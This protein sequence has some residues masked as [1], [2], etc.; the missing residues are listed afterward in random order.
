MAF[1]FIM[2]VRARMQAHNIKT[3]F[4][5][6]A[7]ITLI[8]AGAVLGQVKTKKDLHIGELWHQDQ[9]VPSGGWEESYCWPGNHWREKLVGEVRMMNGTGRMSGLCYGM[10]NWKEYT[11]ITYPY[12]VGTVSNSLMVHAGGAK[13]AAQPLKFKLVLRRKPPITT[14]DGVSQAP[15]QAYDEIDPN[16]VSDAMMLIRFSWE[17]GI[18]V[19]QKFYAYAC[20]NAD[21]YFLVDFTA[22][23]NGNALG[24]E[25]RLEYRNQV[26]HDVCFS[27]TTQPCVSFEGAT[28]N[29]AIWEANNDDWVEY[30][31]ENYLDYLGTGTPLRPAGNR[32]ADSLRVFMVWD[33]DNNKLANVD[34]TGDPDQNGGFN[35]QTPGQGRFLS[36]QY[37]GMGFLHVDKSPTDQ[38]NDLS[39]PFST[40]W[41]PGDV[42]FVDQAEA[43]NYFYVGKKMK[44]PQEMGF[45]EP[46]D[47]INV[48]RP[49][50]YIS[51][52]PYEMPYNSDLHFVMLTAVSGLSHDKCASYG[53]QWWE[54]RRG[55]QGIS[56][57]EKNAI[58][59]TGKDSLLKV[60]SKATKRY[61]RN[62]DTGRDPYDVPDPPPAPDLTITS[63]EKCVVLQWS[64][65]SSEADFD[66]KVKDFS[67][68][69]VYR[70]LG[71]NDTTFALIWQCGGKTGIPVT[72][73]YRDTLVQR[74]FAYYYYVTAYDDGTQNWEQPGV[75]LE[76]GKYWN[77]MQRNQ[78][79]HPYL[80]KTPIANLNSIKVVPNPYHDLSI[81]NNYP[82]E[83]NKIMFIN[84]PPKCTIKI[85][86]MSGDLVKTLHHSDGT[87]E[88]AWNQVT[89]Y[90]QLIYTGVYLYVVESDMGSK[91]GKF[92]IV[93]TSTEE[94]APQ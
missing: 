45:T 37:F 27:Y 21:S 89:E 52:G 33:G 57:A 32:A 34:D 84:I 12:V 11:G 51:I 6:L 82:G 87:S 22:I 64:D 5:V 79:V 41:R 23:N 14:V 10:K 86:T 83:P 13:N 15:R 26:L 4:I 25:N 42:R 56:D 78:P 65:V 75:S 60:F 17:T 31:G 24:D 85:Y 93:R 70:A 48:A 90:N 50:P 36:H 54:K 8:V 39:Q 43:Y 76:S 80:S 16:L 19:E 55:G 35:E 9:D 28:Q 1:L 44:S 68:Y 72:T 20:N 69:K 92:V 66:T 73:T 53:R 71:R 30:Y 77:M 46:N 7:V 47:P 18:T 29:G 94:G 88:E 74:G 40:A 67:G 2:E 49:N 38:T 59:A 81:N 58:V 61:F 3:L 91:V 63:G 62:L